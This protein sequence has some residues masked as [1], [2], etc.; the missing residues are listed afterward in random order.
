[1]RVVVLQEHLAR[2][3]TVRRQAVEVVIEQLLAERGRQV[4]LGVEEQGSDVV[5]QRAFAAALVVQEKWRAVAQ[6][7]VARLEIAIEK[8]VPVRAQQ[9]L[10]EAAKVV[11]QRLLVERD[12]G[13]AEK[14]ILEIIQIPGDRLAVE[15]APRIADF[16]IQVACGLNLEAGKHAHDL[17]IRLDYFGLDGFAGAVLRKEF[18][19]RGVAEILLD[20]RAVAQV[21][22]VYLRHRETVPPKMPGEFEEGAIFF[23]DM[24]QNANGAMAPAGEPDQVSP[25]TTELALQGPYAHDRRAEMLLE[26]L[27]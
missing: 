8:V 5:L 13:E 1:M 24:V 16:V 10:C 6:H 20:I 19:E 7:D 12:A 11:L 18:K 17:A 14:V 25:R 15:T 26:K 9:E 27:L 22:G 2:H 4:R 21:L 3:W 23:A